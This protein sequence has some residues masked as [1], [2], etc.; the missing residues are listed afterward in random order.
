MARVM[1]TLTSWDVALH[2]EQPDDSTSVGWKARLEG[3]HLVVRGRQTY[4]SSNGRLYAITVNQAGSQGLFDWQWGFAALPSRLARGQ[5]RLVAKRMIDGQL[6]EGIQY[7]LVPGPKKTIIAIAWV[8][9]STGLVVR[10]QRDVL[11]GAHL[12]ERDWADYRYQSSP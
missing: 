10:L 1:P 3:K 7:T 11:Q 8:N 12:T 4:L 6:A 2:R 9:P 5:F